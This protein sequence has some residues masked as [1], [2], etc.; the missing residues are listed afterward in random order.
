MTWRHV[1]EP[2]FSFQD[3]FLVFFNGLSYDLLDLC[4]PPP[5]P[6]SLLALV[7]ACRKP[8]YFLVM[9]SKCIVLDPSPQVS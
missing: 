6:I 3:H 7:E 1:E 4:A 8:R 5:P 9:F 2:I